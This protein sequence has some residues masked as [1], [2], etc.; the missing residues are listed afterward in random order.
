MNYDL[1]IQRYLHG[2][3]L[4]VEER[5]LLNQRLREDAALR[6]Q[7]R[8]IAEQAVAFGS[9]ARM[10]RT[11]GTVVPEA[12]SRRVRLVPW[13]AVAASV[14]LLA[15]N[16]WFF[17]QSRAPA[18]LTLVKSTGTVAWTH[19]KEIQPNAELSAG[20]LETVGEASSAL[21]RFRDGTL[22]TLGGEAEMSFSDGGQ[23]SLS[24]TRG[25]LSAEVKPQPAGRPMLVRTPSAEAEVV[26][27]AFALSAR[28]E[29]TVLKVDE[30]LVRLRRLA[31]GSEID[32]PA[33][34]SAVASLD[35]NTPLDAATTPAPLVDWSF[36]FATST[37]PRE[38]RGYARDGIMY[39]SP[40]VAVRLPD[41]RVITHHGVS[42]RT[43][44]LAQPLRLLATESSV[45]RYRLR[46]DRP[47]LLLLMLFTADE[48]GRFAGNF[49]CKVREDELRPDADGWCEIAIPVARYKPGNLNLDI[50]ERYPKASGNVI[51]SSIVSTVRLDRKLAVARFELASRP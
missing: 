9:M 15:G 40:Y 12:I 8:M 45:I 7:M 48:E 25:M 31:D 18:V 32:V 1:L 2:G 27:T 41:G 42:I 34:S 46:V 23:K 38:W 4:S 14:A 19:G 30:G 49:E 29:D 22:I 11:A 10:E 44:M 17:Q 33:K 26:G 37:P 13:L 6:D 47:T 51:V 35:T 28:A 39:A 20:T 3:R 21:L 50:H 5:R 24:L 43:A 16:I 36:D